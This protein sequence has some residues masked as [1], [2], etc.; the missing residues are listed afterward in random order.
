MSFL[1]IK[2]VEERDSKIAEYL[3]LKNRLK[4]RNIQER[5]E[6]MSR[7]QELEENFEPV[8]ASNK[9]MARDIVDEL[10]P[11]TMV[12]REL[13]DKAR[14]RPKLATNVSR[15]GIKRDSDGS[16]R[17][18]ERKAYGPFTD[19]FLQKYMDPKKYQIDTTF[20]IRYEN[21]VWMIGNKQIKIAGDDIIIDGEVY[22]GTPGL[23]SLITDKAPKQYTEDDL[24]RYK[25]L[26]HETSA[27]HQHYDP[28]SRYPRASRSKK[29]THILRPIWTEFQMT[30][31]VSTNEDG[32]RDSIDGSRV[33]E[34]DISTGDRGENNE[35]DGLMG[36]DYSSNDDDN[37]SSTLVDKDSD[38]SEDD[39]Q[40][41]RTTF[42]DD[43]SAGGDG[44][45]MYLQKDDR[46]FGVQK[47]GRGITFIP[48]PRLTGIRGNGLYLRVG[49]SIYDGEGLL[50]GPKSPFKK[51]P[52][53][54][55][56][57]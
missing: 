32:E 36:D 48:R 5:G 10:T 16:P 43:E 18:S 22:D 28:R 52:I 27:M 42:D 15:V 44:M 23:W 31:I 34:N 33:G 13:N 53:L 54:G 21:G 57:L 14:Q 4:K 38:D 1:N 12:L 49:S 35:N 6:L 39:F 51:I 56:I 55:W 50:L 20:G 8:V 25:E 9:K 41:S 26:L 47:T 40:D 19:N 17:S 7:R 24:G 29:W 45:K 11:I 37:E 2:N 30:G 46:C 3:A